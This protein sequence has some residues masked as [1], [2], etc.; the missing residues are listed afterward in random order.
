MSTV[1]QRVRF[2]CKLKKVP[3]LPQKDR[4]IV[5]KQ[6]ADTYRQQ[7]GQIPEKR[8]V[9]AEPEGKFN[10]QWYPTD[11]IPEIDRVIKEFFANISNFKV[12][13]PEIR[14]ECSTKNIRQ[15]CTENCD[16]IPYTVTVVGHPS[17]TFCCEKGFNAAFDKMKSVENRKKRTRIPIKSQPVKV[18]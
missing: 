1:F 3:L 13:T 15:L 18:N 17:R 11:F 7:N 12:A 5:G 2:F 16:K 8:L 14:T 4:L 6:V 9:I 10:V